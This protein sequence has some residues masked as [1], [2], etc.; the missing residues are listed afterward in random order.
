PAEVEA[1]FRRRSEVVEVAVLACERPPRPVRLVAFVRPPDGMTV[2]PADLATELP[3]H[4]VPAE[5][6]LVDEIPLTA[7]GKL[8]TR[9]L[10]ELV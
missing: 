3:D 1:A 9:A 2:D 7:N 8:D 6:V 4:M 10:R 5:V